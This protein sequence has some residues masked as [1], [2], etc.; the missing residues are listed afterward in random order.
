M[1]RKKTLIKYNSRNWLP[2]NDIL[3]HKNVKLFINHG[4]VFGMLEAIYHKTPMLIFPFYGDQHR[5]AKK[6]V[7]LNIGLQ[8]NLIETTSEILIKNIDKIIQGNI[9]T[10]NINYFSDIYRDNPMKPMD[11]AM[12]WIEYVI[13]HKGAKHLKSPAVNLTWY[14]YLLLDVF[15]AALTILLIILFIF[16]KILSMIFPRK[17]AKKVKSSKKSN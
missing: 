5:N 16:K 15:G 17:I 4:G 13:R 9:Y 14:Q 6:V 1:L 3:A 11:T 8:M 7:D 10:N 12:Y 2:Q